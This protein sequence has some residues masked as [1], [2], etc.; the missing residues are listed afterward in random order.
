MCERRN[1]SKICI[2]RFIFGSLLFLAFTITGPSTPFFHV[3]RDNLFMFS[4]SD[5]FFLFFVHER[6]GQGLTRIQHANDNK[7]LSLLHMVRWSTVVSFFLLFYRAVVL[8]F[9]ICRCKDRKMFLQNQT[10][11][12]SLITNALHNSSR[13]C[14]CCCYRLHSVVIDDFIWI[15]F[16][17]EWSID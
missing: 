5:V 10:R 2:C 6:I 12:S 1:I 17:S 8:L 15:W 13:F 14:C 7:K 16:R 9:A 11:I 3:A 4:F